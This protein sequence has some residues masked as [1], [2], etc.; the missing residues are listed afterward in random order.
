MGN[1]IH[2][3]ISSEPTKPNID[4]TEKVALKQAQDAVSFAKSK[5]GE[6][7]SSVYASAVFSTD[8]LYLETKEISAL[9]DSTIGA[10]KIKTIKDLDEVVNHW[11]THPDEKLLS[12]FN[13]AQQIRSR[14]DGSEIKRDTSI[15]KP[16]ELSSVLDSVGELAQRMLQFERTAGR[17]WTVSAGDYLFDEQFHHFGVSWIDEDAVYFAMEASANHRLWVTRLEVITP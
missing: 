14:I 2:F 5:A 8:G 3:V 15:V 7:I 6:D 1:H 16:E 4:P 10:N 11:L 12:G 17:D 9:G 13:T